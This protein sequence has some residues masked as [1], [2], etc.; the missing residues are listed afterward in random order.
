MSFSYVI[1]F[2]KSSMKHWLKSDDSERIA[3]N[4]VLKAACKLQVV[5]L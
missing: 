3:K 1:S 5:N 2:L 4:E